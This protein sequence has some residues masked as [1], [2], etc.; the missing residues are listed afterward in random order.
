M[1]TRLF[2]N[3][4]H[5]QIRLAKIIKTFSFHLVIHIFFNKKKTAAPKIQDDC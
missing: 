2:I 4:S 1:K 3:L 5:N